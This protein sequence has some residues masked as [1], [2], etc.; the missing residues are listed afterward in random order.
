MKRKHTALKFHKGKSAVQSGSGEESKTIFVDPPISNPP[1]NEQSIVPPAHVWSKIEM[2]LEQQEQAKAI[3]ETI[4]RLQVS[5]TIPIDKI[6]FIYSS[7]GIT[8]LA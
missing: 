2:I 5:S 6:P 4:N 7:L 1:M 8:F 3:D